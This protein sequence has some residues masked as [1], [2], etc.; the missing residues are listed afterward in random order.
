M[1][2]DR[3]QILKSGNCE[4]ESKVKFTQVLRSFPQNENFIYNC[5]EKLFRY[6]PQP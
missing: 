5:L 6:K 3:D 1:K 4:G 2:Y